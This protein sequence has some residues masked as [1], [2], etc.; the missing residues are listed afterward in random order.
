MRAVFESP[1]D[2]WSW[3]GV[4]ANAVVTENA[5]AVPHGDLQSVTLSVTVTYDLAK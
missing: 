2:G 1:G 5:P 4:H 3:N